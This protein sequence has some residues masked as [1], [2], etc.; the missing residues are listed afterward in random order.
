MST[1][2]SRLPQTLTYPLSIKKTVAALQLQLQSRIIH[3]GAGGR[4]VRD[5]IYE[6]QLNLEM[7]VIKLITGLQVYIIHMVISILRILLRTLH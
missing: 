7:K 6:P 5:F 1:K 4:G 2:L 3:L